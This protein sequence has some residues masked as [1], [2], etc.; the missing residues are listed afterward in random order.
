MDVLVKKKLDEFLE[1]YYKLE[2]NDKGVWTIIDMMGSPMNYKDFTNEIMTNFGGTNETFFTIHHW[3]EEKK[4]ILSR[5]ITDFLKNYDVKPNIY[6]WGA[7]HKKTGNLLDLK[8]LSGT[9][10][11]ATQINIIYEEWFY[12]KKCLY[13]EI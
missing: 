13:T 4:K 12:E 2:I 3:I 8:E 11:N 10:Y 5:P 9:V 7:H 6:G 1:K